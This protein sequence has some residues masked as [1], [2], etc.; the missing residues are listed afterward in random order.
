[1]TCGTQVLDPW[2]LNTL[3]GNTTI[4]LLDRLYFQVLENALSGHC[5]P[6]DICL[7]GP[8]GSSL[9]ALWLANGGG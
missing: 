4:N 1:M 7:Q 3:L 2:W 6:E 8:S 5:V 9:L